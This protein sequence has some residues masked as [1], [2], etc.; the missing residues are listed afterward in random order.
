MTRPKDLSPPTG[1]R[2]Q[3][4]CSSD[5]DSLQQEP[6]CRLHSRG[7]FTRGSSGT[8]LSSELLSGMWFHLKF[9]FHEHLRF[10][11]PFKMKKSRSVMTVT[12]EDNAKGFSE[13]CLSKSH[14]SYGYNLGIDL[15][16]GRR[17]CTGTLQLPPLHQRQS[18]RAKTPDYMRRPTTLPL[19]LPPR[20]A[21]TPVERD[22][23]K[24]R[25]LQSL[26]SKSCRLCWAS[27]ILQT[28]PVRGS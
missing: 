20:I 1:T 4:I 9:G 5:T 24:G 2:C 3:R 19:L 28:W 17:F 8:W 18:R 23:L 13:S 11:G 16:K 22:G 21:V 15:W 27:D 14:S 6:I 12:A 26:S 25:I 7:L 10:S